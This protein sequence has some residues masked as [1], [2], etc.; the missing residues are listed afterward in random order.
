MKQYKF[1]VTFKFGKTYTLVA[2]SPQSAAILATAEQ[3]KN[4]LTCDIESIICDELQLHTKIE[5][6]RLKLLDFADYYKHS[7]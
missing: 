4:G 5:N 2:G 3:V 6:V 1:T 7:V